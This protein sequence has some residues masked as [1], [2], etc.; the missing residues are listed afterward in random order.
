MMECSF[1]IIELHL[2][3][4]IGNNVEEDFHVSVP[5]FSSLT[6]HKPYDLTSAQSQGVLHYSTILF[7]TFRPSLMW[8]TLQTT[9][10]VNSNQDP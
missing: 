10:S 8:G 7:A 1:Y 3:T 6:H 5:Y 4:M 9:S 2:N